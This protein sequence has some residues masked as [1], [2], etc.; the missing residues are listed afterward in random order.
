MVIAYHLVWTLY[1][2]WLPNDP[3]GSSSRSIEHPWIASLGA[4]HYG[5]KRSQPTGAVIE[6]FQQKAATVLS[7]SIFLL[8]HAKREAVGDGIAPVIATERYTCYAC[9]VMHDHVHLI[10]RRHRDAAERMIERFQDSI[11]DA[12]RAFPDV[13]ARHPVW[14]GPGWKVFLCTPDE[15]RHRVAYVE[16][17]P[18][19]AG[20]PAQ[21]WS[22]VKSYDG[23]PL[24]GRA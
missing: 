20:W 14:G 17:N 2:R 10:V 11:R 18:L 3:R 22:F 12:L 16:R 21:S 5:R 7:H 23:W 24:A 6:R 1:G 15:V 8:D 4:P 9:A 13:G 19:K